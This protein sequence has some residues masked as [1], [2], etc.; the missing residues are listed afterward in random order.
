MWF[1]DQG[2]LLSLCSFLV[3]CAIRIVTLILNQPKPH[4][5]HSSYAY[6]QPCIIPAP[7]ILCYSRVALTESFRH[8]TKSKRPAAE[9]TRR[10]RPAAKETRRPA[11]SKLKP[12]AKEP[13]HT[14]F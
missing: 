10:L 6:L 8:G 1:W 12:A 9:E 13:R 7:L 4:T 2:S 11:V 3:D 14:K 5:L